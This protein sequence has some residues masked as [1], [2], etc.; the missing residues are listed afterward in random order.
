MCTEVGFSVLVE[1]EAP[2]SETG[3]H[4]PTSLPKVTAGQPGLSALTVYCFLFFLC[5]FPSGLHSEV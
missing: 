2:S 5:R 1:M 4:L 3:T